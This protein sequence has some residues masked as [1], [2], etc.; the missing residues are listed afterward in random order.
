[1]SL[2]DARVLRTSVHLHNISATRYCP[3]AMEVGVD[4]VRSRETYEM[5]SKRP[6]CPSA[7]EIWSVDAEKCVIVITVADAVAIEEVF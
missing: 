7:T 4:V 3:L 5:T 6:L 2:N 1:M